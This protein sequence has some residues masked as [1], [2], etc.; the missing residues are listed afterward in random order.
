MTLAYASGLGLKVH[1][2]D[3]GAQKIDGSTFNIFEMILADFQVKNNTTKEALPSI[4]KVKLIDKKE[5]AKTALDK[6]VKAFVV[7][8]SFLSLKSI[9]PDKI[10]QIT[11]L[12]TEKVIILDEYSDFADVFSE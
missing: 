9:H 6:N 7:H 12:I 2:T 4:S 1:L 3:V 11:S 8:V 5:F 10:A